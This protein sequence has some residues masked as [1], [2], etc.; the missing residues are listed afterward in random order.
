[1]KTPELFLA[2]VLMLEIGENQRENNPTGSGKKYNG[3][4]EPT[5]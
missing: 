3:I 4:Y 2:P 5:L 1:M